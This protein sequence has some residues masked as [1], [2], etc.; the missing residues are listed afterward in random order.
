[1]KRV[2]KNL[3]AVLRKIDGYTIWKHKTGVY[4]ITSGKVPDTD[5]GYFKL[6]SLLKLKGLKKNPLKRSPKTMIDPL[7]RKRVRRKS[8][9]AMAGGTVTLDGKPLK[10][11][12]TA[13]RKYYGMPTGKSRKI[14]KNPVVRGSVTYFIAG[15]YQGKNWFLTER[16]TFSDKIRDRKSFINLLTAKAVAEKYAT[17]FPGMK[18]GIG[19]IRG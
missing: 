10:F 16:D 8:H 14:R 6:D 11:G 4:Q 15:M 17:M 12:S 7:T 19:D 2:T 5:S 13:W 1:M 9:K 3:W 18:F